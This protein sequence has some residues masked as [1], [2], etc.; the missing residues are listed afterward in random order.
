MKKIKKIIIFALYSLAFLTSSC[1]ELAD[2]D[3]DVIKI[4][5]NSNHKIQVYE[6]YAYP[7]TSLNNISSP[8]DGDILPNQIGEALSLHG[9][10]GDISSNSHGVL[11]LFLSDSDTIDKY[12]ADI[13]I[14]EYKIL[15]RYELTI[16]Y[17]ENNNWTI[18]YP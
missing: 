17:L 12:G 10:K 11:I 8:C 5:N 13:W 3:V 7:D 15:K 16:D 4:V 18:R 14:S 2:G 6:S 9:W 1:K